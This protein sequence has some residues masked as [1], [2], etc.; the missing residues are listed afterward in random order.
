MFAAALPQPAHHIP[1]SALATGVRDAIL[2]ANW[3]SHCREHYATQ[4]VDLADDAN[5]HH[6][7]ID[8]LKNEQASQP[9][10]SS[11]KLKSEFCSQAVDFPDNPNPGYAP[12][13]ELAAQR[14]S[15]SGPDLELV[16]LLRSMVLEV[17]APP[18]VADLLPVHRP[19]CA[20]GQWCVKGEDLARF[21]GSE[22]SISDFVTAM[23]GWGG[24][25]V[26][27]PWR[28][29]RSWKT[30]GKVE[31]GIWLTLEEVVAVAPFVRGWKGERLRRVLR[32]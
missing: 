27:T 17:L 20:G 31:G 15:A 1:G 30:L 2:A 25:P 18:P 10:D 19:A 14:K 11:A 26:R 23:L 29:V 6:R 9:V 3:A 16:A 13:L 21:A 12:D 4:P 28:F 32:A 24:R 8:L 5:P 7:Q 22:L